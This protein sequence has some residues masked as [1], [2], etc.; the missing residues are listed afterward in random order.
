MAK[1]ITKKEMKELEAKKNEQKLVAYSERNNMLNAVESFWEDTRATARY[2]KINDMSDKLDY[3]DNLIDEE[4]EKCLRRYD[5]LDF[6]PINSES[7]EDKNKE[8]SIWAIV[9]LLVNSRRIDYEYSKYEVNI[10]TNDILVNDIIWNDDEINIIVDMMKKYGYE[11]I[12]FF[13]NSTAAVRNIASLID[14]GLIVTG[15][16]TKLS[17]GFGGTYVF[18]KKGIILSLPEEAE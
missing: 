2:Y 13:D 16:N 1:K 5:N 17:L 3:S 9:K 8:R 11:R 14:S 15:T 7:E 12:H 4:V 18:D 6:L 10:N